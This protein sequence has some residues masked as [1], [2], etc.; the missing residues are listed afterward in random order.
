MNIH[1][2][3][4]KVIGKEKNQ[5]KVIES[6]TI[7][8]ILIGVD[9]LFPIICIKKSHKKIKR[10]KNTRIH[11]QNQDPT[12]AHLETKIKER[13]KKKKRRGVDRKAKKVSP[14]N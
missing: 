9:H 8:L 12:L 14:Q 5:E 10:K 7:I 11:I 6:I 2:L 13:K 4:V 1:I 3:L